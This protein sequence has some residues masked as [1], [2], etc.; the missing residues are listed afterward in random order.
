MD[1]LP[2]SFFCLHKSTGMVSINASE[3]PVCKVNVQAYDGNKSM[4]KVGRPICELV[5]LKPLIATNSYEIF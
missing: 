1:F 2:Y 3:V 4:L 5:S